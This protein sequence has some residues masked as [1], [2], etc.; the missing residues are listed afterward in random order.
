MPKKNL[1]VKF[2]FS[3]SP[4]IL[5]KQ[6]LKCK[7]AIIETI[8]KENR[9]LKHFLKEIYTDLKR[10][11]DIKKDDIAFLDELDLRS[12]FDDYRETMK[13]IIEFGDMEEVIN[14]HAI[15]CTTDEVKNNK[16]I[17]IS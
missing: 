4:E 17:H 16:H 11:C 9:Q 7:D 13:K 8:E 6:V 3:L 10:R 2:K 1:E 5:E 12:I 15:L 14:E